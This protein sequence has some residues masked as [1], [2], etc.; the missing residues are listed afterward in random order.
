MAISPYVRRLRDALGPA[1]LLFPSVAGL[2]RADGGRLLLVQN[3]DDGS[4]T[5]PGGAI[6]VDETPATAVV[7]EVWE[8]TGLFVTPRRVFGVYGGPRFLVRYDNG[9][10]S[11]Y[12][13]TMF[14]CEIVSGEPRPDGDETMAVRF[15]TLDE[16]SRLPLSPW[17]VDVLPRLYDVASPP[18]FEPTAW[19]PS[20]D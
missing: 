8:E 20:A 13:S 2:V 18:W 6:E 15:L 19:R 12:I 4:W 11:Q 1:R 17:L 14:D 9:D 7:R 16:A 5:T 10:E 3:R